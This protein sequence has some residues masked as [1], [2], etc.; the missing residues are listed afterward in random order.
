M[1]TEHIQSTWEVFRIPLVFALLTAIGL[2]SALFGDDAWDVLS[3][4]VLF[5]PIAGVLWAWRHRG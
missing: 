5:V 1:R 3:W 4:L 2:V